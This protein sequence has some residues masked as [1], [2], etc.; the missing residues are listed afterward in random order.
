MMNDF[1]FFNGGA[2]S[3]PPGWLR[4]LHSH[5]FYQM[6]IVYKGS[7]SVTMPEGDFIARTGDIVYYDCDIPHQE[8]NLSDQQ[9]RII[10]LDWT[11]PGREF[12]PLMH[13]RRGRVRIMADWLLS[14]N[15]NS[16]YRNQENTED[17]LMQTLLDE[18]ERNLYEHE[19]QDAFVP[20]VKGYIAERLAQKIT[21]E[22]LA[23]AFGMNKYTFLR[24]YKKHTGITPMEE[25]RVLRVERA[26]DLIISTDLSLKEIA[27]SCGM[28]NEYNLSRVIHKALN[29]P[30][31]YF[32]KSH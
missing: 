22:S 3:C 12:P 16:L 28:S 32:R 6:L 29:V 24:K 19:Q 30:P 5:S 10:Y 8:E 11:G 4:K 13:D 20:K 27:Q 9:A 15:K 21:L 23:G 14:D 1:M 7:L 2:V 26:R 18:V 31:G 17:N 25:V